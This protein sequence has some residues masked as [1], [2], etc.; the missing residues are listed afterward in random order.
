MMKISHNISRPNNRVYHSE[1]TPP[2]LQIDHGRS[3]SDFICNQDDARCL[4]M[5][6]ACVFSHWSVNK[7]NSA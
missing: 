4:A 7:Y 2:L 1:C 6:C 3:R 5:V